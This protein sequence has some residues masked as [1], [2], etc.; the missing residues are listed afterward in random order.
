MTVF[1]LDLIPLLFNILFFFVPLVLF[2]TTSELFEFNKMILVYILTVLIVCCWIVKSIYQRRLIFRRTILDVPLIIFI[3]S[4]I[5]STIISLDKRT[6][7]FGYYSR[8]N[9][10]LA[11]TVSYALLYWAFVSNMDRLKLKKTIYFL[12]VSAVLVSIYGV[13]E[14]F[15]IDKNLWVQDVQFRIFS[16]LGQPNWLAAWLITLLQLTWSLALKP[17]IKNLKFWLYFTLS[18]LF[19]LTLLYTKSRSGLLGIFIADLIFWPLVF[20]LNL[21]KKLWEKG[22]F[23]GQFFIFN[24]SFLILVSATGTPWTP[25]IDKLFR[26]QTASNIKQVTAT[27]PALETGGTESGE[28]R[29][30]VWKGAID[31]WKHYPIFGTGVETFAFAYY[32]FRPVEHNLVSEWDFIYN[33]AHNEYLNFM[34]TTGTLGITTYLILIGF[35]IWQIFLQIK[36]QQIT[37]ESSS[38]EFF[39]LPIAFLAGFVSILATNF[40]GF[41]VVPVALLFFLYPAIT[42]TINI[43]NNSP[44]EIKK[45]SS[46]QKYSIFTVL[47]VTCYLLLI[48]GRY[49]YADILYAKGKSYNEIKNYPLARTLLLK[50]IRLNPREAIFYSEISQTDAEIA[51]ALYSDKSKSEQSLNFVKAA[52]EES[53]KAII[54]SPNN[55]NILRNIAI[56]FLKLSTINSKYLAN[57]QEILIEAVKLAP[58]DAKLL[59]NLGLT[60]AK[61]GK[62]DLGRETLEKVIFL[63]SNY[64]EAR[65]ALSLIYA[66]KGNKQEAK[67]Q[68][69]FILKNLN[70][71]DT[72]AQ[73]Q[74]EELK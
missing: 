71:N 55:V 19:F 74:L 73:K 3:I 33:K 34:A 63:K 58:T 61:G 46:F 26:K 50:A 32:R 40:F 29:K 1:I 24:F 14:H 31:I 2:P 60:Y 43:D 65:L 48:I 30:I 47:L 25:S 67:N 13:L 57:A 53:Q 18:S 11:S 42:V 16:T 51:L 9:G 72:V 10:G 68:L 49:W 56:L 38:Q 12:L 23:L 62:L 45:I 66:K 59:F 21:K 35:I 36:K 44:T 22:K 37:N 41:S 64:R 20:L 28:I 7:L 52:I 17:E 54:L 5:L 8:F 27:A 39:F 69:E 4:Q 70:P 6:S 15:G